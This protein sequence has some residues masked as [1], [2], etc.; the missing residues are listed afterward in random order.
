MNS[1]NLI[2][3]KNNVAEQRGTFFKKSIKSSFSNEEQNRR[4]IFFPKNKGPNVNLDDPV[5]R[6]CNGYVFGFSQEEKNPKIMP[7]AVPPCVISQNINYDFVNEHIEL[8]DVYKIQDGTTITMYWWK[9]LN[10]WR[11]STAKGYDVTDLSWNGT[12]N[13]RD[14]FHSILKEKFDID[15]K[16]FYSSL[17]KTKCYTWGFNHPD[18]HPFWE[19]KDV[20]GKGNIWF[21]QSVDL[22]FE[23][24][25]AFHT[26]RNSPIPI[27]KPQEQLYLINPNT[28]ERI[29]IISLKIEC[30][31]VL[32]RYKHTVRTGNPEILFG[33]ILRSKNPSVTRRFS[34]LVMESSLLRKIRHLCYDN[35]FKEHANTNGLNRENYMLLYNFTNISTNGIFQLL[36]PQY[37][38]KF[39]NI[40][41]QVD[42]IV[43]SLIKSHQKKNTVFYNQQTTQNPKIKAGME[44]LS[45][46]IN[47][48][49]ELNAD[50][51]SHEKY[52]K[53]V[54]KST[55]M[56]DTLYPLI[57][58]SPPFS[59]PFSP[60]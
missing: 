2:K 19:G 10:E 15:F 42:G 41:K 50:D 56:V 36:F 60:A 5:V 49:M 51:A 18:Y 43:K 59:P 11:F 12:N 4:I 29:N 24:K 26:C 22:D 52:V 27:I 16:D 54:V 58:F 40:E 23:E 17:E 53:Q 21:I 34:N 47:A 55:L 37:K 20:P 33:Y 14:A 8:Y 9:P 7:L 30:D 32:D 46:F 13:Y 39:A 57:H 28:N 38:E 6:E 1:F 45:S 25:S 3:S 48:H 31:E 35:R 44:K